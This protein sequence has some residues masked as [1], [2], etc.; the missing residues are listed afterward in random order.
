MNVVLS[1]IIGLVSLFLIIVILL[2]PAKSAGFQGDSTGINEQQLFGKNK[3]AEALL[4]KV[5]IV[6]GIIFFILTLV[7]AALV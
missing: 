4:K 6:L 1:V 2:Q 5:T 3:G 7:L